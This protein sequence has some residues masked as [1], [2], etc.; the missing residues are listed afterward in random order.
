MI[1]GHMA[2]NARSIVSLDRVVTLR[3]PLHCSVSYFTAALTQVVMI[4]QSCAS[5]KVLKINC[6]LKVLFKN[7]YR[8]HIHL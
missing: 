3:N 1:D 8:M 7:W 4:T 6:C 2:S 5:F